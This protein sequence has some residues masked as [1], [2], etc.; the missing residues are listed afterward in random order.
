MVLL[1]FKLFEVP[2]KAIITKLSI[3]CKTEWENKFI[4]RSCTPN[5]PEERSERGI[6]KMLRVCYIDD[7][8]SGGIVHS[9]VTCWKTIHHFD[10]QLSYSSHKSAIL[11]KSLYSLI[12]YYR[13]SVALTAVVSAFLLYNHFTFAT[14]APNAD[15]KQILIR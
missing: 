10:R 4:V 1:D 13:S 14:F 15:T 2:R 5:K 12:Y 8:E 9:K 11:V 7:K 6:R 3:F